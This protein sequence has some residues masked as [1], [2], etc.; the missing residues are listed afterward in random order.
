MLNNE[1]PWPTRKLLIRGKLFGQHKKDRC[2]IEQDGLRP[3]TRGEVIRAIASKIQVAQEN[4][5]EAELFM[6]KARQLGVGVKGGIGYAYHAVR[7][8]HDAIIDGTGGQQ[9]EP[10]T[11]PNPNLIPGFGRGKPRH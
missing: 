2:D 7:L 9:V 4:E 8:Y 11:N 1:V 3:L 5:A 6:Q 10:L